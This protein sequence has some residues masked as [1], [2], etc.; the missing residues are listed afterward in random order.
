MQTFKHFGLAMLCLVF[1]STASKAGQDQQDR[2]G[3][4]Y[5]Y[6]GWNRA[7]YTTSDIRFNGANYDFTLD[8]VIAKDRQTAFDPKIYFSPTKLTIPQY[9]FRLGYFITKNSNISF[10]IDHMEYVVKANQMVPISGSINDT[11]SKYQGTYGDNNAIALTSDFLMFEH[12]DG[13]NYANFEYRTTGSLFNFHALEVAYVY[14]GGMGIMYPRTNTTLLGKDRYDEFHLAGFGS[15]IMAGVQ[16]IFFKHFFIQPEGKL[17]YI[18]MP[19]IRTTMNKADKA[20][21]SFAYAQINT[22]F[23]YRMLIPTKK[24]TPAIKP[25]N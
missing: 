10:G 22:V 24:Q 5:L 12:T 4:I 7:A 11:T 23:G 1:A 16:L 14:G 21:Q 2:R 6:W 25:A 15:G 18:N 8:D 13:L 9:N 20:H 17:G 3:E 19:D